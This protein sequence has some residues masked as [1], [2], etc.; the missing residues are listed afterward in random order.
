LGDKMNEAP[1]PDSPSLD[2]MIYLLSAEPLEE[3]GGGWLELTAA[4][5]PESTLGDYL[6]TLKSIIANAGDLNIDPRR[7]RAI[8]YELQFWQCYDPLI[9]PEVP[10][11]EVVK[12]FRRRED[13]YVPRDL[14]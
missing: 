8:V 12:I 9:S 13:D 5:Y 7:E 4:H 10:I 3:P 2:L 1:P 11:G 14:H 6:N